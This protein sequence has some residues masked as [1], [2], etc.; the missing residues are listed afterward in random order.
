MI[1]N[2]LSHWATYLFDGWFVVIV[3]ANLWPRTKSDTRNRAVPDDA[4]KVVADLDKRP[5]LLEEDQVLAK[6]RIHA[7]DKHAAGRV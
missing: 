4:S 1:D 6:T 3:I 7:E 5:R 2:I